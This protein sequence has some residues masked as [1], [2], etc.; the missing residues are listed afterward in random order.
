[1]RSWL[2][3]AAVFILA[4]AVAG[5]AGQGTTSVPQ[6]GSRVQSSTGPAL[7][8]PS[9]R[10]PQ[11]VVGGPALLG[12]VRTL[13]GDAAPTLGRRTLAHFY[14]GV[15]EIDAIA[16]GQ[17]VVLGSAT[18]PV[19]MDLLQYQNGSADWMTQ[20]SVPAQTYSQLRYVLDLSSA[21]AVFTDG[22][23]LPVEFQ[24]GPP[25][26]GASNVGDPTSTTPDPAYANAIDVTVNSAFTLGSDGGSIMA[27]FNL[28]ES[29]SAAP[30]A[31][32][33]RPTFSVANNPSAITGT[34]VN[35]QGQPV[36]NA[37]VVAIG[38]SGAAVNSDTT[39]ADGT[40][41][42][43][44]LPADTYQLVIYNNYTNA[45][46]NRIHAAGNDPQPPGVQSINGPSVSV[47]AGSTV[48]AGTIGD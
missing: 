28:A 37:T 31:I 3:K 18:S 14:I 24:G 21:Q 16:N 17:P 33:M 2:N 30:G 1:M 8:A 44:A 29:L 27:D 6:G 7:Q 11:D 34:V 5:C 23:T 25:A 40:F 46:G 12:I 32:M 38:S 10:R 39:A 15:R 9:L 43:H 42:V 4:F 22:T 36:Q 35:A 19:Q 20:T 26:P 41:N 48:S 47:S 13:L 45:A